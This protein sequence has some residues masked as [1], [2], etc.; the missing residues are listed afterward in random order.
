VAIGL[1][2]ILRIHYLQFRRCFLGIKRVENIKLINSKI[3]Q[4]SSRFILG[5]IF[6]Y[7][8]IYKI[9]NPENFARTIKNYELIP[10]FLI[11]TITYMIPWLELILGIMII[12]GLLLR[13]ASFFSTVLLVTFLIVIIISKFKGNLNDCGCF[14]NTFFLE[15]NNFAFLIIRYLFFILIG[16]FIF[17]SHKESSF[18]LNKRNLKFFLTPAI[19]IFVQLILF[20]NQFELFHKIDNKLILGNKN[21]FI[22]GSVFFTGNFLGYFEECIDC[23]GT[24]NL[25]PKI[26]SIIKS[27]K[28]YLYF[29]VGDFS[30]PHYINENK[31]S[32]FMK[33]FNYLKLSALNLTKNDLF[34]YGNRLLNDK[35]CFQI[36]SSNILIKNNKLKQIANFELS[37]SNKFKKDKV[38][39]SVA[40]ISDERRI[41]KYID[42]DITFLNQENAIK[43]I[44]NKKNDDTD[45]LIILYHDNIEKLRN[46]LK[47]LN[48]EEIDLVVGSYKNVISNKVI[49]MNGIP[50]VYIGRR[51]KYLARIDVIKHGNNGKLFLDYKL[52]KIDTDY[53]ND[54]YVE[55]I[56]TD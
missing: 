6:I 17:F 45:L 12:T 2:G 53:K 19:F 39:V 16:T 48:R 7:A 25:L 21:N 35:N 30:S 10:T 28:R 43:Q 50:V 56:N 3:I 55:K 15:S 40:S 8:G 24:S 23:G 9:I 37:L 44:I 38:N 13:E 33:Y 20:G 27:E 36:I 49:Y 29:D 46:I 5:S 26:A 18:Y 52:I 47:K 51:G 42:K 1:T 32:M 34:K 14:P 22:K 31:Y 11:E 54:K 4:L 41:L